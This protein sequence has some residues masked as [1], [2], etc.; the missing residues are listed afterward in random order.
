METYCQDTVG[1]L[2]PL[3][4]RR[5]QD[6]FSVQRRPSL[7]RSPVHAR[8]H[9]APRQPPRDGQAQTQRQGQ[10]GQERIRRLQARLDEG[11]CRMREAVSIDCSST[12]PAS[13]LEGTDCFGLSVHQEA[14][15]L[16]RSATVAFKYVYWFA[17]RQGHSA[18]DRKQL[19][20]VQSAR[21]A[22]ESGHC[23]RMTGAGLLASELALRDILRCRTNLVAIGQSGLSLRRITQ[24]GLRV[25]GLD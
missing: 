23:L 5:F 9:R 24:P 15:S 13:M 6:V 20:G 7:Q 1:L 8:P 14:P 16:A 22:R 3:Q 11:R 4:S 25:H 21:P 10:A 19:L 18:H 17:S 12:L 2:R